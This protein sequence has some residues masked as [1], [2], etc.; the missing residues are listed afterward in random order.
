MVSGSDSDADP[1]TYSL[2]SGPSNGA[3]NFNSDGSFDYTPNAGFVGND[4]FDFD[5]SDG[6]ASDS[7]TFTISV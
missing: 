7:A 2:S 5:A 3:L 4:S 6:L 1:I